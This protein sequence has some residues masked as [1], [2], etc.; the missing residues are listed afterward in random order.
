[1]ISVMSKTIFLIPFLII[2]SLLAGVTAY[3]QSDILP[4]V[5]V[6][7]GSRSKVEIFKTGNSYAAKIIW[8]A[9]ENNAEGL[10]K[11][12]KK[13]PDP[14]LK[15]RPIIGLVILSDLKLENGVWK[16]SKIYSPERGEYVNCSLQLQDG[17]TLKI[18]ATKG[19]FST[20]K[21]WRKL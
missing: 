3:A 13:N 15:S 9:E 17:Y 7:E 8:L 1:M 16:G 18:T 10:P 12:D 20:T 21:Y 2:S 4:G 11:T 19:F 6:T 14:G 5:W